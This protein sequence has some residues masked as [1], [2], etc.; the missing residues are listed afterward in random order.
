MSAWQVRSRNP[1]DQDFSRSTLKCKDNGNRC[2]IINAGGTMEA[3]K[4]RH[5]LPRDWNF[6]SEW[7]FTRFS[8][9]TDGGLRFLAVR[10]LNEVPFPWP[11]KANLMNAH[12][13]EGL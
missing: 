13:L 9:G 12:W 11:G 4:K 1:V 6:K 2:R 7:K 5:T 8:L 10:L 3:A